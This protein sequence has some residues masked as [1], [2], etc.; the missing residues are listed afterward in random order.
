MIDRDPAATEALANRPLVLALAIFGVGVRLLGVVVFLWLLPQPDVARHC[1]IGLGLQLVALTLVLL[2]YPDLGLL[3]IGLDFFGLATLTPR[4]GTGSMLFLL[5][6]VQPFLVLGMVRWS[7]KL[8]AS[9][10]IMPPIAF[11]LL[12]FSSPEMPADTGLLTEVQLRHLATANVLAF[13]VVSMSITIY[14][15]R[16]RERSVQR[17]RDLAEARSRLIDDMSHELRTPVTTAL[18]ATQAALARDRPVES[19]RETLRLIERQARALGLIVQRMLELGRA[20]RA[21]LVVQPVDDLVTSVRR[22]VD[23]FGDQAAARSLILDLETEPVTETTDGGILH[24][25]LGNLLSNAIRF[26]PAGG[27]IEIRLVVDRHHKGKVRLSVRDQG[28]GISPEDLPHI[29]ERYWRADKARSRRQGEDGLGLGLAIASGHARLLG[30][31]IEVESR[32]G[33]GATF[34]VGW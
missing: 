25:V 3:V 2:G 9:L 11:G 16:A 14:A 22:T 34:A 27:R 20:E 5:G 10:A 8:R 31:R 26:S 32:L 12:R 7:V 18:T 30:A 24:M 15:L 29:F 19:Y 13:V 28:P 6:L 33:E 21:E 17:S 1:L 4:F 23:T